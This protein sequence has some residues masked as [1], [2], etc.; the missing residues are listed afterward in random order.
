MNILPQDPQSWPQAGPGSAPPA[1]I[2]SRGPDRAQK[3]RDS[4][5]HAASQD[6]TRPDKEAAFSMCIDIWCSLPIAMTVCG[7]R[8]C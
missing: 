4:D 7:S 6:Q 2:L 3:A 5:L 1:G 8:L